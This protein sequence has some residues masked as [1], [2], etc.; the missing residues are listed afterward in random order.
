MSC[1]EHSALACYRGQ[2]T[3]YLLISFFTSSY[4]LPG[5]TTEIIIII[6]ITIFVIVAALVVLKITRENA[7]RIRGERR[8]IQHRSCKA[9]Y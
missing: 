2:T 4:C 8:Q 6:T 1:L 9:F 5:I 7:L 3:G